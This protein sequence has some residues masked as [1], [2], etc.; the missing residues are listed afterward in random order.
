MSTAVY[1]IRKNAG[2]DKFAVTLLASLKPTGTHIFKGF[3]W[4]LSLRLKVKF[5]LKRRRYHFF[6]LL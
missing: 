6:L 5:A 4:L 3:L 1:S 2:C